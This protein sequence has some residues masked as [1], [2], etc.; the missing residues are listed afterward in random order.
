MLA[1]VVAAAIACAVY[2]A[3]L[4]HSV[5]LK[6]V[7]TRFSVRGSTGRPTDVVV[8]EID[9]ATFD[10][11]R[12][13]HL[14]AQWPY[15]RRYHAR[16]IRNVERGKPKAVAIDIQFTEQTDTRD[17]NA[18]IEAVGS[19]RNVV[20]ATTEVSTRGGTGVLGGDAVLRS[21]G[22]RAGNGTVPPDSDGV[23]RRIP[24]EVDGLKSFGVVAAEMAERRTIPPP[25]TAR[26]WIDFAGPPGTITSYSYWRVLE[27]KVPP[28]AFHDKLVI[29]GPSASTLQD[30]HATS[31]SG[32]E[33]MSGAEI[34]ANVARTALHGFPLRS[35]P[36]WL[37]YLLIA[38]L[39]LVPALASLFLRGWRALA[40]SLAVAGLFTVLVQVA[41][42]HGHVAA[43]T[44]PILALAISAIGV[45][46]I[47]YVIEAFERAL[48]RDVFSRFVPEAVVQQ[49]LARTDG[50]LRLGGERVFGTVVFTD[51]R[52]FTTFS[53]N[54]SAEQV[55]DLL[56]A[57]LT[58]MSEAVL[59]HGGTLISYLGDGLMAIFGA[60]LEQDDHADRAVA[61][62]REMLEERLPRF[63]ES[64][65]EQGFERGFKMGIGINTG[66]FMAGNVGSERR[67]E[68]TAIGD[69]I[70]TASRVEGMTKG[71]PYALFIADSTREALTRELDDLTF[72][73][74]LA[75]RGRAQTIRLWSLSNPA[76]LK[77]DW[78]SE[79][80]SP[81]AAPESSTTVAG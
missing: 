26:P 60:P 59:A 16:V 57:Y 49:V 45:I 32:S 55:I 73:D 36:V 38:L 62:A 39:G 13:A 10:Y 40:A 33:G 11:L 31:V 64:L 35:V 29:I 19:G 17:D 53:E 8:V 21:L 56:N 34:Q 42:D 14:P 67:L 30:I 4:L 69:T 72:V 12:H 78:Q 77:E 41:F 71:T 48:T 18:L 43:F 70:N 68:Y 46:T 27:G 9:T 74:E 5:E 24:Y 23:D 2:A 50:K 75:V 1:G 65:R 81:V 3:D 28:S 63:N 80:G 15:P 58:E 66:E 79:G 51:L 47:E 54:L 52:G 6:T 76:V 44:Y 37:D 25:P 61:A 7:D 20:L 22:A